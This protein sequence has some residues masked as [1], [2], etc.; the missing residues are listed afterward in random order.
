[1]MGGCY[2]SGEDR[3]MVD[4]EGVPS[5]TKVRAQSIVRDTQDAVTGRYGFRPRHGRGVMI[6]PISQ[7]WKSFR[8]TVNNWLLTMDADPL[9]D[10]HCRVRRLEVAISQ[11]EVGRGSTGPDHI[12]G[13]LGL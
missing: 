11:L 8:Q 2:V 3:V 4:R 1:M 6:K 12:E 7:K 10:L 9:E 13:D 5:C